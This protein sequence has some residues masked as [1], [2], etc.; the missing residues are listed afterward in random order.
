[1]RNSGTTDIFN[2]MRMATAL[3]LLFAVIFGMMMVP[4]ISTLQDVGEGLPGG[5][6]EFFGNITLVVV[7]MVG[8]LSLGSLV[9]YLA[10]IF[11]RR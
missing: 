11:N 3:G 8:V 7:A 5:L 6:S 2:F 1:M 4:E 9:V 10:V